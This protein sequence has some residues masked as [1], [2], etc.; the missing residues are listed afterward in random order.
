MR[1]DGN[2]Y[3][4]VPLLIIS[5]SDPFLCLPDFLSDLELR[6]YRIMT[7]GLT[8]SGFDRSDKTRVN[9][10]YERKPAAKDQFQC[11]SNLNPFLVELA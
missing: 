11:P 3:F 4:A 6:F 7:D 1:N 10:S 8:V 5:Y 9:H 2:R